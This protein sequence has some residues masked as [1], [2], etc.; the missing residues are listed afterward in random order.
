M[1]FSSILFIF[2][3]LPAFLIL[4][5]ITP[6]KFRN[7]PALAASYIFYAWGEPI[8]VVVLLFSSVVDYI[9]SKLI[10]GTSFKRLWLILSLTLNVGL[11]IVFKYSGFLI[12]QL[13]HLLSSMNVTELSVPLIVLPLGISFFTFQKLSYVIDVYRDIST[14]NCRT[15]CSLS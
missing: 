13:N 11:L 2:Y 12:V 4:Y 9:L 10:A 15:D 8:F 7:I 5:Y 6:Q 3:F 14:A 1:V